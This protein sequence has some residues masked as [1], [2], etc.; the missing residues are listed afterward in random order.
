MPIYD[1]P[2]ANV[3]IGVKQRE[4]TPS[5]EGNTSKQ[6][7]VISGYNPVTGLDLVLSFLLQENSSK[8]LLEN[9]GGIL[10]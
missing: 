3:P 4:F 2:L 6:H 5:D 7:R 8:L 1:N 9:G 10:K